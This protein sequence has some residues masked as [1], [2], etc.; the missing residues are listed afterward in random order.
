MLQVNVPCMGESDGVDERLGM[1]HAHSLSGSTGRIHD[2]DVWKPVKRL[3][4]EQR[5]QAVRSKVER[6][7]LSMSL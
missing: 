2:V 7:K 6:Y 5:Y 3:G 4:P 1:V